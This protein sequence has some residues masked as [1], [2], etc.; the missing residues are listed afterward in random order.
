M[1]KLFGQSNPSGSGSPPPTMTG[2]PLPTCGGC[3]RGCCHGHGGYNYGSNSGD[4]S[5]NNM[6]SNGM[7]CGRVNPAKLYSDTYGYLNQ[8]MMQPAVQEA[9]NDLKTIT[10]ENT[11]M[12]NPLG[13]EMGLSPQSQATGK[14]MPSNQMNQG[15]TGGQMGMNSNMSGQMGM[16][17][18][19]TGQMGMNPNMSGQTGMN[20]NMAGQTGMNPN[21]SARMGMQGDTMAQSMMPGQAGQGMAQGHMSGGMSANQAGMGP[22]IVN[23]MMKSSGNAKP[24]TPVGGQL[25]E[26]MIIDAPNSPH[27]KVGLQPFPI[28]QN[29]YN[30]NNL[31]TNPNNQMMP[32]NQNKPN[33]VSNVQNQN[34]V[35]QMSAHNRQ[36]TPGT[37]FNDMF[38]G[39]MKKFDDL[40]FDPM[41][42]AIQMN[43][44]NAKRTAM[45]TMQ[46]VLYNND[47]GR[48]PAPGQVPP[49]SAGDSAITPTP[50][51]GASPTP[52]SGQP[53][54]ANNTEQEANK[55]FIATPNPNAAKPFDGTNAQI[56]AAHTGA[57][58]Y[59]QPTTQNSPG[60]V[61]DDNVNTA[62]AEPIFPVDTSK[63][64]PTPISRPNYQY[65]TLGQP[66]ELLPAELYHLPEETLPQT[67]SPKPIS[68]KDLLSQNKVNP[69]SNVK[70]TISKTLVNKTASRTQLQ[71]LYNQY[72]GSQSYTQQNIQ[73]P[74]Q[75][76]THSE[77]RLN[78]PQLLGNQK[79]SP[80][81]KVG[82]DTIA[83]NLV[84]T[85]PA[86]VTK[87]VT[88]DISRA[89]KIP[90]N[91]APVI[92]SVS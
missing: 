65:N 44:D 63:G 52:A 87:E 74:M 27:G 85:K 84:E 37:M 68:M 29:Q 15:M 56:Y 83:N 5:G 32:T 76:T 45:E 21:M 91:A 26:P 64:I 46:K 61:V 62:K 73:P 70:S 28:P 71:H 78:E 31:T 6:G 42:I 4:F 53:M 18:N 8:N 67:L 13:Q 79:L 43:P 92:P 36:S 90:E 33:F 19:M 12:N 72:R 47:V 17:P 86:N 2:H 75:K 89:Q 51:S 1:G 66:V 49:S 30:V 58:N 23:M 77:G 88:G 9:Y 59:V 60:Q 48:G 57:P 55:G 41:A 10:P 80:I 82:G 11:I 16:N 39:V 20:P 25:T 50:N 34:A 7:T 40:G 81:E 24:M 14:G 38:P 3:R 35:G 54:N 22:D 69:Y